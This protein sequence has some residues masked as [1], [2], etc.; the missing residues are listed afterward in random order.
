MTSD[1]DL[2]ALISSTL[3]A[4]DCAKPVEKETKASI[5]AS[6]G[7]ISNDNSDD[8]VD[9]LISRIETAA[10][11]VA[12]HS[13]SSFDPSG[14]LGQLLEGLLTPES[15]VDSMESLA[16]EL[17]SYLS[18]NKGT[19]TETERY[20]K[21]LEIYKEVSSAYKKDAS[22]LDAQSDEGERI[23]NRIND[24]QSLGS[25][26]VEV[27]QKLMLSQMPG[28]VDSASS[29]DIGKEFEQFIRES[30]GAGSI[31][32]LSK[33]DEEIIKSLSQDPDALKKLLGSGSDKPEDC[34]I[35]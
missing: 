4:M 6:G 3:T 25:P 32:G 35:M 16:L 28:D 14:D 20:R 7:S 9:K 24:L 26:P 10:P 31:Q 29:L 8:S 19:V 30:G 12:D 18:H 17:E 11:K 34:S 22:I 27:V 1:K 21:Q 33:E 2:D 15:I 13:S 5:H 23:R